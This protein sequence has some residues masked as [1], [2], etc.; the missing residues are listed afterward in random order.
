[1]TCVWYRRH[2][3]HNNTNNSEL[4]NLVSDAAQG[5]VELK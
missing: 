1:M 3:S 2:I 5:K 4:A